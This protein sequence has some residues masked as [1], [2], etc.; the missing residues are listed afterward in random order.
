VA[1]TT[2]SAKAKIEEKNGKVDAIIISIPADRSIWFDSHQVDHDGLR[3]AVMATVQKDPGR[4]ILIKADESL[5][6]KDVRMVMAEA[7]AAGA[8]G[9]SFAVEAVKR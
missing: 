8:H 9:V 6:V 2:T 5:K 7:E 4:K 3:A 1:V